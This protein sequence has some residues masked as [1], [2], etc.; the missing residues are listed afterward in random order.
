MSIRSN[1]KNY[2]QRLGGIYTDSSLIRLLRSCSTSRR[3]APRR[4]VGGPKATSKRKTG[5]EPLL[6]KV[7]SSGEKSNNYKVTAHSW[8]HYKIPI[9]WLSNLGRVPFCNNSTNK[10]NTSPNEQP[11]LWI[12]K[13]GIP[14]EVAIDQWTVTWVLNNNIRVHIRSVLWLDIIWLES[15]YIFKVV[16]E[17]IYWTRHSGRKLPA[18]FNH[19]PNSFPAMGVLAVLVRGL[20]VVTHFHAAKVSEP[21]WCYLHDLVTPAFKNTL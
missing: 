9:E 8:V 3:R 5:W 15:I 14:P 6:H 21:F 10:W 20:V 2:R 7:V 1:S 13:C 19:S 12:P 4:F 17:Q 11:E 18:W 16:L